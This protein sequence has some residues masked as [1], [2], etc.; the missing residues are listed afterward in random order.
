LK[1]KRKKK[2]NKP[3]EADLLRRKRGENLM[4]KPTPLKVE[5]LGVSPGREKGGTLR[6]K[7]NAQGTRMTQA[8]V[9]QPIWRGEHGRTR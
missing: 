6:T 1:S 7:R 8:T 9:A 2:K 3:K 5:D 4:T